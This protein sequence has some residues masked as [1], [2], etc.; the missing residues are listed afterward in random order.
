VHVGGGAFGQLGRRRRPGAGQ[1]AVVP[2]RSPITTSAVF[3][4]APISPTAR[5]TKAISR[6][7]SMVGSLVGVVVV[8][9][10]S[11]GLGLPVVRTAAGR[12][13]SGR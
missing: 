5:K 13:G 9:V 1:G 2:E 10:V 8:M 3:S 12:G 6:S 7:P 4:V 11:S